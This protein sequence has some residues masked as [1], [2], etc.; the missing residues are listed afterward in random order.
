MIGYLDGEV[1]VR[2]DPYVFINVAGV[3]YKVLASVSVLSSAVVGQSVSVFIYTHVKEDA[4][5]LFAFPTLSDLKLFELLVSV[6]GIGPK[7][8]ISIFSVGDSS[9]IMNAISTGDVA[10]FTAVPRLGKKNAQKLIIELKNKFGSLSEFNITEAE[11][12]GEVV[13]ALKSFGFSAKEIQQALSTMRSEGVLPSDSA[14]QI[15]S[16]LKYLGK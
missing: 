13:E 15:K 8:A 4:L 10:F 7:T 1:I 2:D 6:S 5:E 14:A 11:S 16:A 3:G 12:G 9:T